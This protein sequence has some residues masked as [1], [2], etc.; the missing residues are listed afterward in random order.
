VVLSWPF[1]TLQ[2]ADTVSGPYTDVGRATSPYTN[3][4]TASSSFFR[5]KAY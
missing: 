1:G 5:V 3:S 4:P 2:Q